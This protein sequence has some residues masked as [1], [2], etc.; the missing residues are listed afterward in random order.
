MPCHRSPAPDEQERSKSES[1]SSSKLQR[2]ANEMRGLRE[3]N[4]EHLER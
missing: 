4:N 1:V 2:L 3:G